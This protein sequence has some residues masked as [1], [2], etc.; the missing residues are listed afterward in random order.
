MSIS[1][2]FPYSYY[3]ESKELKSAAHLCWICISEEGEIC[4]VSNVVLACWN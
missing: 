4:I 2:Q 1:A 3:S